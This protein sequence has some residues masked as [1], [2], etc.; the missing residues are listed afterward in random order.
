MQGL[1]TNPPLAA[2]AK[3]LIQH[4]FA[5]DPVHATSVGEHGSDHKLP[6][7]SKAGRAKAAGGLASLLE[8]LEGVSE[9]GL[10][11]ADRL[12]LRILTHGAKAALFEL[13]D[14]R[15]WQYDPNFYIRSAGE[16]VSGLVKRE[17]APPAARY[18]SAIRRIEQF[19]AFFDQAVH[20]LMR[21]PKPHVAVGL[22]Q[23]D[24]LSQFL[25]ETFLNQVEQRAP[26][27]SERA[28][29][30]VD[31][32]TTALVAFEKHLKGLSHKEGGDWRLGDELYGEKLELALVSGLTPTALHEWAR[33]VLKTQRARM[34]E[35]AKKMGAASVK[36]ALAQLET[37]KPARDEMLA[38]CKAYCE[39]L[40]AFLRAHDLVTMP[41]TIE[42]K[43][44]LTPEFNRGVPGAS[45]DPPGVL[46]ANLPTFFYVTPIPDTWSA[47][48][49]N[50]YLREYNN[51]QLR[52]LAVHEALPGHYVQLWHANRNGRLVP[53]VL[54]NGAFAEGWAVYSEQLMLEA[55]LNDDPRHELAQLKFWQRAVLNTIIDTGLHAGGMKEEEALRLLLEEGHQT[56]KVA[57]EK[58]KRAQVSSVQ[59]STYFVGWQQI[60]KLRAEQMAAK[61][62]AFNLREFNDALL[63]HG[64]PP[65]PFLKDV[66]FNSEA[67][68]TGRG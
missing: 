63:S 62:D 49:A 34:E 11:S 59:L 55:G 32:A 46:E 25:E 15:P 17:F 39:E 42:L 52:I 3:E 57:A 41:E 50:D 16:G 58:I 21:V 24:G 65:L 2:L 9:A 10:D 5:S 22:L 14:E 12:D 56:P 60:V 27:L 30:A 38:R 44:E 28:R 7:Y 23:V 29:K 48:E 26:A 36:D 47:D 1:P 64:T 40:E 4:L 61:G 53:N 68:V 31:E 67:P 13:E 37:D 54:W 45:C 18:E 51:W 66:F 20:N 19:P 8:R 33:E 6:D 43:V 35:V